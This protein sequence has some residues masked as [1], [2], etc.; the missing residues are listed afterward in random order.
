MQRG[1]L[2]ESKV[3]WGMKKKERK[4]YVHLSEAE[5]AQCLRRVGSRRTGLPPGPGAGGALLLAEPIVNRPPPSVPAELGAEV[6]GEVGDATLKAFE[7]PK[8]PLGVP[9][10]GNVAEGTAGD[11]G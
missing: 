10:C 5:R 8:P 7:A 2:E 1:E 9:G 3:R 4:K 6:K 11:A